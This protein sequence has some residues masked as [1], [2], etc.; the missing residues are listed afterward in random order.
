MKPGPVLAAK[1]L[2]ESI[3]VTAGPRPASELLV[4]ICISQAWAST[5]IDALE[6]A[7]KWQDRFLSELRRQLSEAR[8]LGRYSLF[9]FNSSSEYMIQGAAFIEPLDPSDIK[10]VKKQASQFKSYIAALEDISPREFEALCVGILAELGVDKTR[11]SADEGI[12]FYGRLHLETFLVP[13]YRSPGIE[14]QLGVWMV[15]QAKHYQSSVVSTFDIRD[16]V[17]AVE[18]AKAR[19]YGIGESKYPDLAIRVCDPV[20]YIFI[21]TGRMS[22][23]TWRLLQ[24]SGMIGMDGQMVAGF[25][26]EHG[27]GIKHGKF[28]QQLMKQWLKQYLDQSV[29]S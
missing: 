2:I 1:V 25:L 26:A 18:L 15:G 5:S 9:T 21:T 14:K 12:D 23:A 4:E 22:S 27:I 7:E 3:D 17:G 13:T 28:A 16:L 11:S 6:Y 8:K 24:R 20:F 29:A 10:K 19:A